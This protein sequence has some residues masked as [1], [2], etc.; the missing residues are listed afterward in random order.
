MHRAGFFG[1]DMAKR[2]KKVAVVDETGALPYTVS[3]Y[4]EN[5]ESGELTEFKDDEWP[6]E[7]RMAPTHKKLKRHGFEV[8][9]A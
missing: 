2:P 5:A 6:P 1:G 4:W 7:L 8:V 9:V 3:L